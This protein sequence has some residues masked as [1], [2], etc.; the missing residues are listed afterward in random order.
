MD[1]IVWPSGQTVD[2]RLEEIRANTRQLQIPEN[3]DPLTAGEPTLAS[4]G[5]PPMPDQ[6]TQKELYDF[7]VEMFSPPLMFEDVSFDLAL[8]R[9]YYSGGSARSTAA[10]SRHQSSLNWSGA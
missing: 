8:P 3:F 4:I 10:R 1:M 7:W 2:E 5:L 9:S 6:D